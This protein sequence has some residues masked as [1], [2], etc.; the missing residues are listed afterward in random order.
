MLLLPPL[1]NKLIFSSTGM[2]VACAVAAVRRTRFLTVS[3]LPFYRY[4]CCL[5]CCCCEK[6]QLPPKAKKIK[7]ALDSIEAYKAQQLDKLKDNYTQ[8]VLYK[9]HKCVPAVQ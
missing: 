4:G 9:P 3:F 2:A 6:N 1:C 7:V 8:Q 5:C